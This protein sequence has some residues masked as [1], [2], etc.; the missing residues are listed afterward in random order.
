[1]TTDAVGGVWTYA[2]DLGRELVRAGLR[3]TLAVLGPAPDED[4]RRQA[5]LAG[6]EVRGLGGEL[7]WTAGDEAEVAASAARL[8][9]LVAELSPHLIHLNSPALA[10]FDSLPVP[11][12][13]ACHSCVATWWSA[14]KGAAPLPPDLAWR[15]RLSTRGYAAADV[16]LA[17]SRAFAEATK[18]A[19]GLSKAPHVVLNGRTPPL[20]PA[21]LRSEGGGATRSVVT[22]GASP[23]AVGTPAAATPPPPGFASSPA[24]AA[25]GERR[26]GDLAD[27]PAL[28]GAATRGSQAVLAAGRLWDGGKDLATLDRASGRLVG[29]DIAAAGPIAG[30]GGQ[31]VALQHIRVL[32]PLSGTDLDARLAARPIFVSPSLY[33]PFGLAVLEA[34][35]AGCPLALSD[36]ATFRELWE[37]A[38]VFFPPGDDATLTARLDALAT[39]P[40]RR[41]SLGEA[42][43]ARA[44]RYTASAMAEAT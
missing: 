42:A 4:R 27:P 14:V 33:E 44:A 26:P 37:G 7:D 15:A 11:V 23:P 12:L 39:D 31:G 30:P 5:A 1:M 32:G 38:A 8:S 22:E 43:H 20:H 41:A 10:A 2:L 28:G 40:A 9:A 19:Y 3:V 16:L 6:L 24:P 25:Q 21:S 17:P 29:I 13:A 36:I 34:A 35:Q 18:T